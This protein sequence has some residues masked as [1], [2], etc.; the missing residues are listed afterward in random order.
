L[1]AAK[2]REHARCDR[3]QV[4]VTRTGSN[5]I[6]PRPN[7]RSPPPDWDA[8]ASR[9]LAILLVIKHQR[10]TAL[11][12]A[13]RRGIRLEQ[14]TAAAIAGAVAEFVEAGEQTTVSP[15]A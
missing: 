2:Q 12:Q 13:V 1:T 8:L 4:V 3:A 14:L 15:D 10:R 5:S 11:K 9:I 6:P 7:Q